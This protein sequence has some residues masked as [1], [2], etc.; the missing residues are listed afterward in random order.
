MP[1]RYYTT[2]IQ[3]DASHYM[4]LI[5]LDT[6]P[7]VSNY[8]RDNQSHWDPCSTQYPTCSLRNTND[9]FEGPCKFHENI[10]G[11]NCATQYQWLQATLMG[12]P[13]D[14]WL[15]IVGHHPIDECDV[16][17]LTSLIQNRGFGIYLNGHTHTMQQ[18]TIDG[19]GSYVT[20][21]AGSM[22]NTTD[23]TH[24]MSLLK[25]S[26]ESYSTQKVSARSNAN[27][28]V[29]TS[30][31][32]QTVAGFTTHT[33][34]SDFTTL[35]TQFVGYTGTILNEIVTNRDG[36]FTTTVPC[37]GISPAPSRSPTAAP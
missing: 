26:G 22:V 12:I 14:D 9:D 16:R 3:L 1:D 27:N 15:V 5:V 36:S 19:K 10:L 24:E 30:V 8:R 31:C 35:T 4:S 25:L 2:R 11:Q 17:D 34:N 21:G 7:C 29:F 32:K 28:H 33:F 13:R 18:Y 6:S 37:G 20:T 23:Q